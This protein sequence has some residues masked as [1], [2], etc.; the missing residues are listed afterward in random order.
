MLLIKQKEKAY[1]TIRLCLYYLGCG[2]IS[3]RNNDGDHR[4][5]DSFNTND[6][7]GGCTM[8]QNYF[9]LSVDNS[10]ALCYNMGN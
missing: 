9:K 4:T 10:I 6:H 3:T 8:C 7:T 5:R 2:G 1:E